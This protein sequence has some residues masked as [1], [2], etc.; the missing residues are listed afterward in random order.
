MSRARGGGS[1]AR[2][3]AARERTEGRDGDTLIPAVGEHLPL[4]LAIQQVVLALHVHEWR[5]PVHGRHVVHLRE[6]PR[7]H[8]GRAEIAHLAGT[9]RIVQRLH[10]LLDG[11]VSIE[12]VDHVEVDI[13]G[14]YPLKRPVDRDRDVLA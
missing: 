2:K 5:P 11:R 14:A 1:A 13:V 10:G 6:L 7:I 4:F 3:E 12:S 9:D 8:G